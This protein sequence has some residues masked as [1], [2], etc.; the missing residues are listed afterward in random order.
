MKTRH[1]LWLLSLP[2]L[3]ASCAHGPPHELTDARATYDRAASGPA[4]KLDP[5]DVYTA[6]KSLDE[7]NASFEKDGPSDHTRDLAYVAQRKAEYA[8][9]QARTAQAEHDKASAQQ[10]LVDLQIQQANAAKAQLQQAQKKLDDAEKAQALTAQQLSQQAQSDAQ[11]QQ[12]LSELKR[13]QAEQQARFEQAQAQAQAAQA[14]LDQEKAARERAEAD[15]KASEQKAQEAMANLEKVAQ[16]KR[17]AR[18]LVISLSG[19]VLFESGHATLLPSATQRLDQVAQALQ[20][21]EPGQKFIVEGHT[22]DRGGDVLNQQ[23]SQARAD[24][25]KNY[26][27]ARGVEPDHITAVGLGKTGP[28][29]SNATAEGRANNR[30]VEI[31]IQPARAAK[32][33]QPGNP[34]G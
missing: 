8:E 20:E 9:V 11:R 10:A 12:E 21:G 32:G 27:V 33:E 2:A 17:E 5:A 7:A 3:A 22:D 25:V 29:A 30:R 19:S 13:A 28:V 6:K 18:G 31:V 24:A 26:L 15:Q 23:L 16:V 14:Q 1:A 34:R 4:S